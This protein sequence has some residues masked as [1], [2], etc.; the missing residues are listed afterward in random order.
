MLESRK[1][2]TPA[3]IEGLSKIFHE[4]GL[5]KGSKVLDLMC[6]IGRHSISLAK[7]GFEVVG[8]DLS[9]FYLSKA[10]RWANREGLS[11]RKIRFYEGDSR[12]SVRHLSEND[13]TGF[14]AIINMYTSHGYY[15]EEEDLRLFKE[16]HKISS[17]K[18]LLVIETVNRD[19]MIRTFEQFGLW[20][21]TDTL[22]WHETRRLNLE[23]S[24]LENTWKFYQKTPNKT[25]TLLLELP[26][27]LRLYSLHEMKRLLTEA[28]WK[29]LKSYGNIQTL[30][31][32]TY[33]S[34]HMTLVSQK[35]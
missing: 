24:W 12:E 33:N 18:C 32:L 23:T 3:E 25:L 1:E 30:E 15:G 19:N 35:P 28:G 29:F 34:R 11:H 13:E 14:N 17:S 5:P 26:M 7:K 10:K 2:R 20:D 22:E 9:R 27:T 31:P 6:G 16:L 8:F 4:F 21:M